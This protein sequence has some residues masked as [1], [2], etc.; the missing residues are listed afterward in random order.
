M[1][2]PPAVGRGP[3]VRGPPRHALL[4]ALRHRPQLA[5][6]GAGLPGRGRPLDLRPLP[7]GG[8]RR[9]RRRPARVDDDAL[10]PHLQRGRRR[11][12][13]L[14]LRADRRPR[15]RPRPGPR[16]AGGEP[17][18]P[19]RPGARALDRRRDGRGRLA[20]PAPVRAPR[21]RRRQGRLAGGGSRLRHRRRRLGHR[22]HRSRLRRGRR[23]GRPRREPAGPQP[24]RC[25]CHVRPPGAAVERPLR[26]GRRPR[27]HRRPARP[28]PARGRASLRAQ[29][30]PL[31]AM[32]H[33]AH[34]LGQDVVVRPHRGEAGRPARPERDD[35]L[36]PR[37]HQARPV[38]ALARGQHRLGAVA[39]PLLGI[40]TADLA[41][42][43]LRPRHVR[44]VGGRAVRARRARPDRPRPA[45]ALR[46]RGDLDVRPRRLR[47]HRPP[48]A[49][50][51]RRLVRLGI[52]A[53]GP[54]A[55]PVR[56]RGAARRRAA[57]RLPRR[58][59]LRGDRPDA[60]LVLLVAGGEHARVRPDALPQRRLPRAHRRRGRAED[61]QVQGQRHRP[62]ADLL[63]RRRR[64]PAVVL[65][66]GRAAV[67]APPRVRGRHPRVDPADA[68]DAVERVQLLRHLRRPRRLGAAVGRRRRRPRHPAAPRP[69][70]RP[71]GARRARRH[72]RRGHRG[73]R[74]LRRPAR[75]PPGWPGSS[76]TSPTGTSGAA[77]PASGRPA[78]PRRTPR[79]TTPSSSPASCWR[80]SARSWPTSSTWP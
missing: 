61:V 56:H 38:R 47:G 18:V 59:H 43:R 67:D 13:R 10:D 42:P 46:R 39:R 51:A 58:L 55:P 19:R 17:P 76:T 23:P 29:L 14:R 33:A 20:L 15:G 26:Q 2:D 9:P 31:L 4:R 54:G 73:A 11:R 3:A 50:G 25:R 44:G 45:P 28:G 35:R 48:P 49:A 69:R 74:G 80:P 65:L 62:L 66:L 52:D 72:R 79:C 77:A 71:L 5:R 53:V 64:Q 27:D 21:A 6:G 41:V 30:P 1:A 16:R 70:P 75:A 7:P 60:G 57:P 22:P 34:L 78:I 8:R 32:R 24:R 12:P 68:A 40:A 37:A 63:L 36:V